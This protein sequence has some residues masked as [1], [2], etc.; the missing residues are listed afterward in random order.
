MRTPKKPGVGEMVTL[1][2][3]PGRTVCSLVVFLGGGEEGFYSRLTSLQ[4]HMGAIGVTIRV[5]AGGVIYAPPHVIMS[6]AGCTHGRRRMELAARLAGWQAVG[7]AKLGD[8]IAAYTVH[9]S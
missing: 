7:Y 6:G 3:P 4:E 2:Y 1:G 5:R 8:L 9:P